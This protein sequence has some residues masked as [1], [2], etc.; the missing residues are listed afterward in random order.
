MKYSPWFSISFI[1]QSPVSTWFCWRTEVWASYIIKKSSAVNLFLEGLIQISMFLAYLYYC[2][3]IWVRWRRICIQVMK[4]V[5]CN[6]L[7]WSERSMDVR[8]N[9]IASILALTT[10]LFCNISYAQQNEL[11]P[12][13]PNSYTMF[14]ELIILPDG[15]AIKSGNAID[16]DSEGNAWVFERCGSEHS[17]QRQGICRPYSWY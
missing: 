4:N 11:Q 3:R 6:F 7:I 10:L 2:I 13:Y 5:T 14:V 9:I 12:D 1:I 15:R 16:V 8:K 17:R